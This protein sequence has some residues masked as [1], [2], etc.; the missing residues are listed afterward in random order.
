MD[1]GPVVKVQSLALTKDLPDLLYP[2]SGDPSVPDDSFKRILTDIVRILEPVIHTFPK[3]YSL[4]FVKEAMDA[5]TTYADEV[6]SQSRKEATGLHVGYFFHD[7]DDPEIKVAVPVCFIEARGNA[8]TVTCEISYEEIGEVSRYCEDHHLDIL[9]WSHSHPG[10]GVFYSLTDCTTLR[11]QFNA[12]QHAGVVVDNLHGLFL[13]YKIFDGRQETL[14]IL[15][16][17]LTECRRDGVLRTF[18]YREQ[19]SAKKRPSLD[20]GTVG[21]TGRPRDNGGPIPSEVAPVPVEPAAPEAILHRLDAIETLLTEIKAL[22][23]ARIAEKSGKG[24]REEVVNPVPKEPPSRPP[25]LWLL[26][27]VALTFCYSSTMTFFIF[28]FL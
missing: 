28:R 9:V 1:F 16:F 2:S 26:L 6:Y 18:E 5:F 14:P 7:P 25:Y 11:T 22:L 8:T 23:I 21:G 27:F 3:G 17:S 15:G 19:P 4:L 24:S 12:D 10:F 20:M 13:A